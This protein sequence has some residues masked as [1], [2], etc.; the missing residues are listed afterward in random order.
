MRWRRLRS[1]LPAS[2]RSISPLAWRR[3]PRMW[4]HTCAQSAISIPRRFRACRSQNRAPSS[5]LPRRNSRNRWPSRSNRWRPRRRRRARAGSLRSLRCWRWPRLLQRRRCGSSCPTPV[6]M[7]KS[8]T[9]RMRTR[10]WWAPAAAR[11]AS[12]G[13]SVPHA[14]RSLARRPRFPAWAM[15]STTS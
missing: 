6:G 3:T 1:L 2:A 10:T 9:W 12:M 15:G 13:L 11:T 7:T 8:R 14:S 4:S 5:S